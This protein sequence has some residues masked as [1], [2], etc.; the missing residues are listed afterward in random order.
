MS[1]GRAYGSPPPLVIMRQHARTPGD[2]VRG[3]DRFRQGLGGARGDG[4][5]NG[6][7]RR[8]LAGQAVGGAVVAHSLERDLLGALPAVGARALTR[9]QV[10]GVAALDQVAAVGRQGRLYLREVVDDLLDGLGG[11]C[12]AQM[13]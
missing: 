3:A 11:L 10:E 13:S 5:G 8:A 12:A 2:G 6:S 4:H 1:R 9:L 7:P